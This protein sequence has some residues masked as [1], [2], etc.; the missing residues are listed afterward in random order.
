MTTR[1]ETMTTDERVALLVQSSVALTRWQQADHRAA[2]LERRAAPV[3]K[4]VRRFHALY[5]RPFDARSNADIASLSPL[6]KHY[7]GADV[8]WEVLEE[9]LVAAKEVE[10]LCGEAAEAM[11][12]VMA[13]AGREGTSPQE[14]AGVSSDVIERAVQAALEGA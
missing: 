4:A 11:L 9:A 6:L 13:A 10:R 8:G 2:L 3:A 14:W 1:D 7:G 5:H 12:A